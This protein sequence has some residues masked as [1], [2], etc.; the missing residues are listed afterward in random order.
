ME[1]IRIRLS[2]ITT[3]IVF[4]ILLN[5]VGT[6]IMQSINS[7]G[8]TES[9]AGILEGFK[10]LSI[11]VVSFVVASFLPRFG[12]RRSMI[13]GLMLV[14]LAC[15]A[16]PLAN[17]FFATKMMFMAVGVAFALVKVSVYS[18][19]GLITK[20]PRDH[21][22]FMNVLEGMFMVGVLAGYWIFGFFIGDGSSGGSDWLDVYWVLAV[23]CL[24]NIVLLLSTKMDESGSHGDKSSMVQDFRKMMA[25][26]ALP[27]VLVFVISAFLYVLIEQGIGTWLPNFNNKVLNLPSDMSVQA[28]SIFAASLAIG[29]L[30]AGAV[31]SRVSWY[32]VLNVCVLAMAGLVLLTLPLTRGL[33][34]QVVSG[35]AEAPMAAFLFPLIGL[36]MAPIYPAINS[37]ILSALP[38]ARHSSMTG[39]IV[40]F[41]ALGGTTGSLITGRVFEAFDGQTA[42]YLSLVPMLAILMCLYLFRQTTGRHKAGEAQ[43]A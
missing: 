24:F 1:T 18:S 11:A 41:S 2:L 35:W 7:F 28:T 33:E 30:S 25:L 29:R 4:A 10:D 39:L 16:M 17:S 12:Y 21:A 42:F 26:L 37:V 27:M 36:F 6:V 34:G 38:T 8:V 22:G 13:A 9:A 20:N 32:P 31:L 40:I 14:T 23:L 3:Y 5:S 19:I 43:A 15:L